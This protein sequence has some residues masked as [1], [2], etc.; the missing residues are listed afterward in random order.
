MLTKIELTLEQSQQGVSNDVLKGKAKDMF[1]GKLIWELGNEVC[2][3]V[4]QGTAAMEKLVE[5][6]GNTEDKIECNKLK[7]QGLAT[8]SFSAPMTQAAICRI[9]KDSVDAAIAAEQELSNCKDG[10]RKLSG[11][12][13]SKCAEGKK[14]KFATATHKGLALTWWKTKVE[15]IGLETMNQMPWTKIKQLMTLKF[16]SIEEV[17]RMEHEIRTSRLML[18]SLTDNIKGEMTSFKPAD[19]NEA[20]YM[21]HNL[22]E[23]KSQGRDAGILEGKKRNARS[24]VTCVERL[25]RRQGHTRNQYLKKVRQ[26]EVGE[27]RGRAY[28]IK[29]AEPQ[30]LNVVTGASYEVELADGR[31]SSTKT[32]LKGCTLNLLNHIFKIDPMPIELGTFDT[33]I[34]MDWLIKQDAIIV[35]GEKVVRIPYG[36]EMLIDERDKGVSRLKVVSYIKALTPT[37][38]IDSLIMEDEHLNTIPA[39]ESDELNKSC[40]ENLVPNPKA[41]RKAEAAK[42]QNWKLPV[43]YDDDDDEEGYNSLNDNIISELPPYSAVIPTEPINSLSMGDEHLDTIPATE[44]NKFIKSSVENLVPNPSE[45]KGENDDDQSLSDEDVPE[46]IYSNPLFDE[47]IIPMEIDQHSFN[48]ESDL[49]ESM[50]NHDSSIIISSK[51]DSLF[52][53][54]AGELTLLKSI[55]PGIDETNCHPEEEI[56]LTK[57]LLYDNSSPCP[58]KEIV[59]DNSNADIES[60]SPSPIPNLDSDPMMEETD[61]PFTPDNP[62][63]PSIKED[64]DDSGRDIPIF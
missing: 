24:S 25:G 18:T 30:G 32:I 59:S 54:F 63:T 5:K 44:S 53:E 4:E 33:I 39:T 20:V 64:D 45:S 28:A 62:M 19:L 48:A 3:S 31:V 40:V 51:I 14:V 10:L 50:P 57:R 7:K 49:I 12:K 22:M 46:K 35:C 43:C 56:R 52:D 41:R 15:T 2:S 61:L 6:L 34:G 58:P 38:P 36:N 16:C 27:V 55:P 26:E 42:A 23:Q 60:F 21:A 9:I 17:Q 11:F 47:E 13:I 8:H 29:D 37:E 1:Y